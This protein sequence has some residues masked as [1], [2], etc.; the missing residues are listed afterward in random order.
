[1]ERNLLAVALENSKRRGIYFDLLALIKITSAVL[2]SAA[3]G[4][5]GSS[6]DA[7]FYSTNVIGG[8]AMLALSF[9]FAK[10]YGESARECLALKIPD[11]K[12]FLY[13]LLLLFGMF[14]GLSG[15]NG[16]FI[17]FLT[18]NFGY[19]YTEITLPEFSAFNYAAVIVAVCA[20]PAIAE[21]TSFRGVML[22]GVGA[23]GKIGGAIITGFAFAIYHA[24]P[25]QTAYQFVVGF[26]FA[27]LAQK[28][29]SVLPTAAVHFL[30]NFIIVTLH[31]FFG[32]TLDFGT[33]WNIVSTIL[34]LAAIAAF[35]YLIFKDKSQ[36]TENAF[37]AKWLVL[38][39]FLKYGFLG[40]AAYVALW[41]L[42]LVAI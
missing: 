23:G 25:A 21:E 6:G 29:G 15:L 17:D 1:M 41:I 26:L 9:G 33:L 34:G 27:L 7:Y 36:K 42:S 2:L 30:N 14:F 10:F 12:Y 32:V 4:A 18:K 11:K 24:S 16:Y 40:V 3:F 39:N 5:A 20:L 8:L 37:A 31:Y 28:S 35:L 19:K 38:R 13:A 22:G